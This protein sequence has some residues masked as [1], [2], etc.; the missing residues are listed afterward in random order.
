[1]KL[2]LSLIFA[3]TIDLVDTQHH[4]LGLAS[5]NIGYLFID[6]HQTCPTIDEKDHQVRFTNGGQ[7]LIGH[8]G[9]ETFRRT[10]QA[11]GIDK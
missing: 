8:R 4:T 1:M 11:T 9:I 7:G 10:A 3:N 5:E 6:R 2:K